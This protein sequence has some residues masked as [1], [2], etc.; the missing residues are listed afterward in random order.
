MRIVW[1]IAGIAASFL[2]F[3]WVIPSFMRWIGD[4]LQRRGGIKLDLELMKAI[5]KL[6]DRAYGVPIHME[7]CEALGTEVSWGFLYSRMKY[8]EDRGLIVSWIGD[9]APE[10]GGRPKMFWKLTPEGEECLEFMES[11]KVESRG[12]N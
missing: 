9:P 12:V 3:D 4:R 7:C 11:G 6:Q 1:M 2:L 10:R 5:R 8:L